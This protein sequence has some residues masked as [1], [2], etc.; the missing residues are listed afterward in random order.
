[1]ESKRGAEFPKMPQGSLHGPHPPQLW[2]GTRPDRTGHQTISQRV[3][4]LGSPVPYPR[5]QRT[6]IETWARAETFE[7]LR[8]FLALSLSP[9]LALA[10]FVGAFS[11]R[12]SF[13]ISSYRR[14]ISSTLISPLD[15]GD[16]FGVAIQGRRDC[17]GDSAEVLRFGLK[18]SKRSALL[19]HS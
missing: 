15:C 10:E 19:Q 14:R 5:H 4:W 12:R 8:I 6:S 11:D 9:H 16:A 3:R 17:G 1:M 2:H 7:Q 18:E 13:F